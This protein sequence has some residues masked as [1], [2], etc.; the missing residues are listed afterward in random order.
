MARKAPP[1]A[2][3]MARGRRMR[4]T[5]NERLSLA[6]GFQMAF[7]TSDV[8]YEIEPWAAAALL[9]ALGTVL[10]NSSKGQGVHR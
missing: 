9:G 7:H 5:M 10:G 3:A 1:S 8:E 2:A 4:Q 6:A